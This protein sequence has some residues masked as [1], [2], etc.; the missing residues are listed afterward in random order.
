MHDRV[1]LFRGR[2]HGSPGPMPHT[3]T[4]ADLEPRSPVD[5]CPK[6]ELVYVFL[7]HDHRGPTV[8]TMVLH[9][10]CLGHGPRQAVTHV[11]TAGDTSRAGS[12][13]RAGDSSGPGSD[14]SGVNI[15]S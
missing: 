7:G 10:R 13:P 5:L 9:I 6:Q 15:N 12:A 11:T 2:S 1:D 14:V 8:F 3:D 4:L